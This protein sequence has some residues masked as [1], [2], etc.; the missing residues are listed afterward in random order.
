MNFPP[1][2]EKFKKR[3]FIISVPSQNI[4]YTFHYILT[5]HLSRDIISL[6]VCFDGRGLMKQ[7]ILGSVLCCTALTSGYAIAA[8]TQ[9]P[10]CE[11]MGYIYTADECPN[12]GV[13]CPFDI[14][15]YFCFDPQT[16]D[17]TYTAE[18]CAANCQNVGS[19]SCVR[20]G[21]TYYQSCGSSKCSSGQNCYN[22]ICFTEVAIRGYCCGYTT[23]CGYDGGTS[24]SNDSTCQSM[25]GRN[26]YQECKSYG[27]P[28]C[29]D[30]QTSCR[31][32]GNTPVFRDCDYGGGAPIYHSI[33]YFE[34]L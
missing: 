8:C 10:D 16:C 14:S 29:N 3:V 11:T 28:D 6:C 32:S 15:K 34:C 2:G 12:G 17:Y 33:V 19:S 5:I 23:E 18:T 1:S 13:K 22:G 25:W 24:H 26:C 21:T 4:H 30:M 20:N 31:A 27:L 7:Y 9:T